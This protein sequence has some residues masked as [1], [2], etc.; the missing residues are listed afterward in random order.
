MADKEEIIDNVSGRSGWSHPRRIVGAAFMAGAL[1]GAG[2]MAN[3]K[4]HEKNL[5]EKLFDQLG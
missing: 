1:L 2:A 5:F 3:K 4:S